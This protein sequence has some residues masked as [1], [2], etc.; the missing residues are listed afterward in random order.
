VSEILAKKKKVLYSKKTRSYP[1]IINN[2]SKD[3]KVDFRLNK[4]KKLYFYRG[5]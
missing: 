2:T 3:E 5:L 4:K 1:A